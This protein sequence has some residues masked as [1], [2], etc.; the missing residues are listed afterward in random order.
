MELLASYPLVA[1]LKDNS[2]NKYDGIAHG[3]E[4]AFV[5]GQGMRLEAGK[6]N[7]VELPKEVF[8]G[9]ET[10]TVSLWLK[11]TTGNANATALYYGSPDNLPS[12]YWLFNPTS[13]AGNF[14]SV[15]TE[16]ENPQEPWTTEAGVVAG[17]T[18]ENTGKWTHYVTVIEPDGI[19]GYVNGV[20]IGRA[21]KSVKLAEFGEN[22]AAYIGKSGYASDP[23]YSGIF[24]D[25][26]IYRGVLTVE[27]IQAL[28]SSKPEEEKG[29][30]L[31]HYDF[32]AENQGVVSDVSGNGYHAA[33]K[34]TGGVVQNGELLL[35]GGA[36][37]SNGAYVE[38]P[39][40]MF[41]YRDTLTISLWLKNETPKGNFAAMYFGTESTS[42]YWLMNPG[43]ATGTFKSVITKNTYTGEYGFSPTNRGNGIL[44]PASSGNYSLYTT[45]IQ[46]GKISLYYNGESCGTVNTG[47][48]V[49]DFGSNL[50]AYLGRSPYPDMFFQGRIRDV[51]IY[52]EALPEYEV[53][54]EYYNNIG[55]AE[56]PKAALEKDREALQFA[57]A[58]TAADLEL[59]VRGEH[60]SVI[61]WSSSHP[62]YL[63]AKGVVKRPNGAVGDVVV[64][65]T[66]SLSLG[67]QTAVKEM[68]VKVLADTPENNFELMLGEFVFPQRVAVEDIVLPAS[69]GNGISLRWKSS[70]LAVVSDNGKITRPKA[71]DGNAAAVLTMTAEYQ[72]MSKVREYE[73]EVVE[74]PYGKILT[75]VRTGNNART[76]ALHLAYSIDGA[77]YTA[78]NNN[79]PVLYRNQRLDKKMGS[80]S[81]F[82]K[83]DGAY[84]LIA[85]DDNGSAEV[86][87]YD[88]K[89]LIYFT[90]P[91][92]LSLNQQQVKVINPTCRY[93]SASRS[94]IISYQGND[95]KSYD[96]RTEDF[97]SLQEPVEAAY[98]KAAVVGEVPEGAIEADVFE[99]TKQEYDRILT[100][101][102]RVVNTSVSELEDIFIA[103]NG[104]L[105]QD[106]LPEKA[107]ANYSDGSTKQFGIQWNAQ[108]L[109]DIDTAKPG[110]YTVTGVLNQPEYSD[111]LVE[112]RAD[113]W[114]FLG[115]DGYYYFTGSY[116]V[117]GTKEEQQGIGYDRVVLRRARTLQGLKNAEEVAIWHADDYEAAYRYI[118]APEIHQIKGKWFV[119]YT[120]SIERANPYNIR[121]HVLEC[122]GGDP[123]DP[124]NWKTHR[125][126]A[127]EGDT[128]AI[129]QFS[130]DMT[131]FE[132]AG[133]H[134]VVWA[135]NPGDFSNLYIATVDPKEPWKL[136]SACTKVTKPDF[137]WENPINE[138]PAVIKNNGNVYLCY[139]AAA[140]D[141]SY[142]VGML[143]AKEGDNLLDADAW[144]KYPIALLS[145]DDLTNQCGPGHNSFTKDE[146]G[147][148][149]I[150]YHAR[151]VLECSSGG[152]WSGAR[153]RCEYINPG[154]NSLIDPCRHA[155]VK[156]VNF[157]VDGTPILNMTPE[158]ELKPEW[159]AIKVTVVVKGEEPEKP[160]NP[161][162]TPIVKKTA[163]K[164]ALSGTKYTY[165]G[166]A[167]TPKVTVK[168][169]KGKK[170]SSKYYRITY[171]KGRKQPGIY[172][173]KVTMK[174]A[175]TGT[176]TSSFR[177]LPAKIA[178][179]N[180]V[181]QKKQSAK[182]TWKRGKENITGYEIQ[183][184]TSKKFSK[185]ATKSKLL[186]KSKASYTIKS[187][188]AKKKY[189]IRIRA[190][191]TVK[192]GKKVTKLY[193]SWSM[194][195]L[196]G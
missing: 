45:V 88:S 159:K 170:I 40:G 112:Q 173:V 172:Q 137:A 162:V 95:G 35:P 134:Y 7:Y 77:S 189:Y 166:K 56:I 193:S 91:R 153:G 100:K 106:M 68:K 102:Q 191:K 114:A 104:A 31:A 19:Q 169:N 111:I 53:L 156:S 94:Y 34:G 5:E 107:T 145:T 128:F 15:V 190:Y 142:C 146:N 125:M 38:L 70:N 141:Y 11:G 122:V 43:N 178:I 13:P 116:P 17:N 8:Q 118:W 16:R 135:A 121:P 98:Q 39:K 143:S 50:S 165:N 9:E 75:Y 155:R 161:P 25:L 3:G 160:E 124:D 147:N 67:G 195:K 32:A 26:R 185:K 174:G 120:A 175:Y 76:D 133:I 54:E 103:Q 99:V 93:D 113:P 30:L 163:K 51:K 81:L 140:V 89:D 96:V 71:G 14:K 10:L 64:T 130:L 52:T 18:S 24:R 119:F 36:A 196:P 139:S 92:V 171:P 27:D 41:D 48:S 150:V 62:E 117:C 42:H 126:Q 37:G 6:A 184:S 180:A 78:L 108:E 29:G 60:G 129:Q 87:V 80:P 176:L 66:A 63:S 101:W 179:K 85:S 167:K 83:A 157:A 21:G 74:Q 84:G 82:R 58:E 33:L 182:I 20:E 28:Y 149:V 1:D 86:V 188:K 23:T 152:D 183:Y 177:I 12:R 158:E 61:A 22:V 148:P 4:V 186:K 131:H 132:S 72:G 65:L 123:M 79:R 136:T 55:D 110:S 194:K 187:L 181:R 127:I 2:G 192:P 168:D 154:E 69:L 97:Q 90:N 46:P 138:G 115:D 44:G 57:V 109:K 47:I 144:E 105:T 73:I 164:M 59:P 49:S 151:P